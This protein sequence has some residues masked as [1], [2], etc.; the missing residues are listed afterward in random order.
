MDVLTHLFLP[1]TVAFAVRPEWFDSPAWLA[2]GVF[3]L[4]SD[5]D[6]FVGAPGLLHSLVGVVPMS[7]ALVGLG[8]VLDR[9]GWI[10]DATTAGR[11]AAGFVWSHLLL[12]VIDGGPVPLLAPLFR[13]GLGLEYPARVVFGA[14]P[15]GLAVSGPLVALRIVAPR[16]GFNAYGF[17][18][19]FGIASVLTFAAIY[20]GRRSRAS[21]NGIA[22]S[23]NGNEFQDDELGCRDDGGDR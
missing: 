10:D 3:G 8:R 2:L 18:N 14:E 23:D 4:F 6:K 19:G 22:S 17:I 5:F 7:L 15:L 9:R 11:L 20:L 16:P 12:D 13:T 21:D 1:L